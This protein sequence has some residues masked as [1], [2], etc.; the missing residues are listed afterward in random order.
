MTE[1]ILECKTE[2]QLFDMWNKR[3]NHRDGIFI[4]DGVVNEDVW[5]SQQVKILF[6]LKEAY[7]GDCDWSLTEWFTK[8]LI[9]DKPFPRIWR[10][11]V[12]WI[13]ALKNT[14]SEKTAVYSPRIYEKN[15]D[16][17]N[18]IS[19][20]NIKK[21]HGQKQS[22][23]E[24]I[25]AYAKADAEFIKKQLE[26]ISP[27]VIIC[28]STF[29]A[30]NDVYGGKISGGKKCDNWFYFTDIITGGKTTVIDFYHPANHYP[31]LFNFYALASIYRE[32]LN[33]IV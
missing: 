13:Y 1:N 8:L 4:S 19:V 17:I 3:H 16:L 6:L 18:C 23:Y 28:G 26:L 11:I 15:R 22:D 5:K 20:V 7:G 10:R 25:L 27:D 33:Q 31:P 9:E 32:S 12:E 21:S 14:E 29:Y 2:C 30:L 24:E